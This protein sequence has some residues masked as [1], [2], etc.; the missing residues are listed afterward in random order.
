MSL[1]PVIL[2]ATHPQKP[3]LRGFLG[4]HFSRGRSSSMEFYVSGE[5]PSGDEEFHESKAAAY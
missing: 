2:A 5:V 3:I 1:S 4:N